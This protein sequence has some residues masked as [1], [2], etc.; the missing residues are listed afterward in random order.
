MDL[1][2]LLTKSLQLENLITLK[3]YKVRNLTT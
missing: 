1:M 2:I 3:S